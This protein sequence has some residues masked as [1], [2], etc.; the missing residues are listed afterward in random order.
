MKLL[1]R[2]EQIDRKSKADKDLEAVLK[3]YELLAVIVGLLLSISLSFPL[4]PSEEKQLLKD[5]AE[6]KATL[7]TFM[8]QVD[9]RFEQV[10]KRFEQV[11]RRFE[12]MDKRISELREDMNAR[13]G[14]IDKRFEQI[15]K[16]FE[17]V[18]QELNR[19]VQVMVAIFAGQFTLVGAVIAF[20]WWDRR[21]IIREAKRQ[22]L[23]ELERE[24]KPEKLRRLLNVLRERA[25]TDEEL[26]ELLKK[27]GLL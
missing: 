25:K 3:K 4:T 16:R 24:T 5:I 17:Q 26:R 9:K 22:T 18:N 14:Q 6:I 8:E 2:F 23:E 7:K 13:F 12:Q 1:R 11:D 27:E 19:M 10:D 21:T 20:A 15:D